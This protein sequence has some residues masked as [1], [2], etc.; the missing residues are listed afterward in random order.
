MFALGAFFFFF[1]PF[2]DRNAARER[3]SPWFTA[4]FLAV[5]AY[6]VGFQIW[7]YQDPGPVHVPET[8][9]AETYG[10]WGGVT[11]LVLFWL[12]IAF[13]LYYLRQLLIANTQIRRLRG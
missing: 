10:L 7:A 13:L 6:A 2:L 3:R 4:I 5:V 1:V 8:L 12:G 11:S 9:A